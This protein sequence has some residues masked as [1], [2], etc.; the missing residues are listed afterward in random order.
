MVTINTEM[1]KDNSTKNRLYLKE[2]LNAKQQYPSNPCFDE[3]I[4]KVR[5]LINA[6]DGQFQRKEKHMKD[7][8]RMYFKRALSNQDDWT[9][10]F[11]YIFK[12]ILEKSEAVHSSKL[13][14]TEVNQFADSFHFLPEEGAAEQPVM[15]SNEVAL[16]YA[17]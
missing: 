7:V 15:S 9:N 11:R 13:L 4:E 2:L 6:C 8:S 10:D 16:C 14:M 5:E 17:K 1:L 12:Y 3:P